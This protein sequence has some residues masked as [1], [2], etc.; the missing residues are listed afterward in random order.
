MIHHIRFLK[1]PRVEATDASSLAIK[2]LI[3]ITT[4]LGDSFLPFHVAISAG[5][6]SDGQLLTNVSRHVWQS[7][8]RSLWIRFQLPNTKQLRWPIQM[9]IS[10]AAGGRA[11]NLLSVEQIPQI[12]DVGS[13]P[14]QL[15]VEK[16]ASKRVVRTLH[17]ASGPMVRI[18]EDTDDSIARHIW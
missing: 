10:H 12:I 8:M 11:L 9:Q 3:T 7:G 4:D 16:E 17:L 1:L 15:Q 18:H 13:P 6:W 14:I 2:A 5:L